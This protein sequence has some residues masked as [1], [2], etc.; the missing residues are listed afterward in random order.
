[1][2]KRRASVP[3]VERDGSEIGAI[4]GARARRESGARDAMT[5]EVMV[6]DDDDDGRRAGGRGPPDPDDDQSRRGA[7]MGEGGRR[8]RAAI[9]GRQV[10]VGAVGDLLTTSSGCGRQ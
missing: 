10:S 8:C 1:M 2:I 4:G 7:K 3:G 9:G 6:S 5:D